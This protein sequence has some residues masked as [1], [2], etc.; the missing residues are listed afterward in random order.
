MLLKCTT[1]TNS[2]LQPH[3]HIHTLNYAHTIIITYMC[4]CALMHATNW[5]YINAPFDELNSWNI[6]NISENTATNK[7]VWKNCCSTN[8]A[9]VRMP[10]ATT[11]LLTQWN[12]ADNDNNRNNGCSD[13]GGVCK[14][15]TMH[16]KRP[17]TT[18]RKARAERRWAVTNSQAE[19][20]A[21]AATLADWHECNCQLCG[22][23]N[24]RSNNCQKPK[25]L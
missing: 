20:L 2:N 16:E 11:A 19:L 18:M 8:N 17:T 13:G 21:V 24:N 22:N 6:T 5:V 15:A 14:R 25:Q 3:T 23:D 1:S 9:T 7:A 10:V 12:N 4:V